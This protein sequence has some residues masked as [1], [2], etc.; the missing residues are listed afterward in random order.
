MRWFIGGCI[1]GIVL[2]FLPSCEWI[3]R[4]R[5]LPIASE[6]IWPINNP[7]IVQKYAVS[8]PFA[9]GKYHTGVD[10]EGKTAPCSPGDIG[11]CSPVFASA[12]GVVK[13]IFRCAYDDCRYDGSA[14]S[15]NHNMQGVV[16][17]EHY[18][19]DGTVVFSLYAHLG[20]ISE[21]L[22][23]GQLIKRGTLIGFTGVYIRVKNNGK[24]VW[25]GQ[26][27]KH[28]HFEIKD[29]PTL[30][31]PRG[32]GLYWGYTPV[33]PDYYGYCNPLYYILK[34]KL[35]GVDIS[36]GRGGPSTL[37][38]IDP[39]TGHCVSIGKIEGFDS[40][41]GLAFC[42]GTLFGLSNP[43]LG[44]TG[45]LVKI[46]P[47]TGEATALYKLRDYLDLSSLTCSPNG[48]LFATVDT[49][50][51]TAGS[52]LIE[53]I[54]RTGRVNTMGSIG[55]PVEAIAFAP[56]GTLF[57]AA[58]ITGNASAQTLVIIDPTTGASTVVGPFGP[59]FIDV[60]ALA[61]SPKHGVLFGANLETGALFRVDPSTASGNL[62]GYMEFC[63]IGGMDFNGRFL[64]CK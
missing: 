31:N 11:K 22:E 29:Q 9:D 63:C 20:W 60:D 32:E 19:P 53:I 8:S 43:T 48:T 27:K 49:T 2:A 37:V 21:S 13:K 56:D 61:F 23:E 15:D 35:L 45:E 33:H 28:V 40:I 24:W 38:A 7:V 25:P 41:E 39:E 46:D 6:W 44:G 14:I 51:G 5:L 18:L 47:T 62:I 52:I 10:I 30:H 50:P 58:D 59:E 42:D 17:L 1:L 57:G 36:S 54:P 4:V 12:D 3:N 34:D 55:F 16:I 64:G 26:W